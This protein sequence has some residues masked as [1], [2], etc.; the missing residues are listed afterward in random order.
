MERAIYFFIHDTCLHKCVGLIADEIV[1]GRLCYSLGFLMCVR[2]SLRYSLGFLMCVR[3]SLLDIVLVAWAAVG[4]DYTDCVCMH[5]LLLSG[6][7]SP[8]LIFL[9]DKKIIPPYGS[10]DIPG[11][12]VTIYFL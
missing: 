5:T 10:G 3:F 6:G 8:F 11:V 2:F 7:K 1:V 9:Y 4:T 12:C